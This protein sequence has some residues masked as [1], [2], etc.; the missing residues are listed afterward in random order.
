[1]EAAPRAAFEPLTEAGPEMPSAPGAHA[2]RPGGSVPESSAGPSGAG[3][4]GP[5][6][7]SRGPAP[8]AALAQELLGAAGTGV[9]PGAS[10]SAAATPPPTAP[11]M[12][13]DFIARNQIVERYISG[14]LPI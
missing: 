13:R 7:S 2:E 3:S 12:D 5:Y 6:A 14:R 4:G 11:A 1:M 8:D 10:A 9:A